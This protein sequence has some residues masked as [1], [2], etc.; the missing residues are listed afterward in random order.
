MNQG[1]AEDTNRLLLITL[2]SCRFDSAQQAKVP[3]L[4][5]IADLKPAAAH[6]TFTLPAHVALFNGYFPLSTHDRSSPSTLR[7]LPKAQRENQNINS[8]R[9]TLEGQNWLEG[10]QRLGW[11]TVGAGG[12]RWFKSAT[13][14]IGFDEFIYRGPEYVPE[15]R[16]IPEWAAGDFILNDVEYLT[17]Q[18]ESS[19]KWLLFINCAET[20]SPYLCRGALLNHQRELSAYRNGKKRLPKAA[21]V[22][23]LMIELHNA[24][25][26]AVEEVDSKIRRLFSRLPTPFH[27]VITADHGEAFGEEG[28]WGH[29]HSQAE[30]MSVPIWEGYYEGV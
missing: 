2:D 20:H 19:D 30:V 23:R 5:E 7:L 21:E 3:F 15:D 8:A 13:L 22:D 28:Y 25:V 17:S 9:G 27:F 29:V 16:D 10:L 26:A 14:R 24:Q 18:V 6:G 4:S 1:F 11:K 12:M